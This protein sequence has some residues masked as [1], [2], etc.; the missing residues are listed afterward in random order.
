MSAFGCQLNRFANGGWP[1]A[2]IGQL[3][4]DMDWINGTLLRSGL[5]PSIGLYDQLR[6]IAQIVVRR[7]NDDLPR[8]A[9]DLQSLRL[10]PSLSFF[11]RRQ[12][13]ED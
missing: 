3:F 5:Y 10:E 11:D 8:H 2:D 7:H 13:R 9:V 4:Q 6:M 1:K 12:P